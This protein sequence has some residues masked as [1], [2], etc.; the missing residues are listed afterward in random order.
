MRLLHLGAILTVLILCISANT[1]A[2]SPQTVWARGF[3]GPAGDSPV[4]LIAASENGYFLLVNSEF[5]APSYWNPNLYRLDSLGDTLWNRN[6]D[7]LNAWGRDIAATKDGGCVIVASIPDTPDTGWQADI[8]VARYAANGDTLWTRRFGGFG[9]QYGWAVCV[10]DKGDIVVVG[11]SIGLEFGD[12]RTLVQKVSATGDSLWAVRLDFGYFG[13][14]SGANC[15]ALLP[16]GDYVIAG[17]GAFVVDAGVPFVARLDSEGHLRSSRRYWMV[18]A[19]P[20]CLAVSSDGGFVIA[21][22]YQGEYFDF[23]GPWLL[24]GGPTS[25]SLWSYVDS[26]S[27]GTFSDVAILQDSSILTYGSAWATAP[28]QSQVTLFHRRGFMTM[29]FQYLYAGLPTRSHDLLLEDRSDG[30]AVVLSGRAGDSLFA[31]CSGCD[32]FVT[33][34]TNLPLN[35]C[36]DINGDGLGPDIADLTVLIDN[37]YISLTPLCCP[38]EANVDADPGTDISDLSALIDFLYI[39][40]TLPVACL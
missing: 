28:V 39:S 33:K 10:D 3:G 12:S 29:R 11:E 14:G 8:L 21:G 1:S 30:P 36:C 37:L 16:D 17:G 32:V 15:I 6:L 4:R 23:D 31:P 26:T 35:L 19:Y 7:V 5:P 22:Q 27:K 24:R 13:W 20:A 25:D 40:F 34:M 2:Q 18:N 38:A 9:S